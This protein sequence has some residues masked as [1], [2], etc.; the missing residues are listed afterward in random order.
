VKSFQLS[1]DFVFYFH[2][3]FVGE[4]VVQRVNEISLE[5]VLPA[6][7]FPLQPSIADCSYS[8]VYVAFIIHSQESTFSC[9]N[10]GFM[11]IAP[12]KLRVKKE[13][14]SVTE[15]SNIEFEELL[16]EFSRLICFY[17]FYYAFFHSKK[18]KFNTNSEIFSRNFY[19]KDFAVKLSGRET[20]NF[21]V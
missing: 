11:M 18:K 6:R 12:W 15:K 13:T 4:K 21:R 3:G 17:R 2:W 7:F 19:P 20:K 5:K 14:N 8:R 10:D 1:S 9:F 16:K